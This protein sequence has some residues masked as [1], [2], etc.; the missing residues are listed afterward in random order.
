MKRFAIARKYGPKIVALGVVSASVPSFAAGTVV[1]QIF[2]AIGLDGV[3]VSVVA[4]GVLIIGI[5][6]AFK[7][8]DLG[9]R[10]VAKI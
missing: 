2:A 9:K 5:A 3:T 6:M 7:S 4:L 8:V 10:G 1:D